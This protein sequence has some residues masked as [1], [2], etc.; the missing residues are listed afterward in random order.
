MTVRKVA[1]I[2]LGQM[3]APMAR[4]IHKAGFELT[5]CDLDEATMKP[6]A[7]LGARCTTR[8]AD[9]ADCDVVA[10]VV[11]TPAQSRTV[12]LGPEG[13]SSGI[14]GRAPIVA[15]MGTVSP[16]EMH[17]LAEELKPS[18]IQLVDA[19][20]SGG[21]MGA[22][23]GTLA[24]MVGGPKDVF[25]RVRPLME[26]MGSAI[27][28]CGELGTAQ[29]TKIVNNIAGI[30]TQMIAAE[31]YRI[32]TDNGIGLRDAI[33]VFETGTGR[34]FLTRDIADVTRAYRSWT[35]RR[36]DFDN[37]QTIMRKDI[38][39][40]L[41][42]GEKSGSLPT[43]NALFGVLNKVGEETYENWTMIAGSDGT[44]G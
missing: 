4:N 14:S 17:S 7:A 2:G 39:L 5:V 12:L 8:A 19:P 29:V 36:Q 13:I 27:Y 23:D 25:A 24:I 26:S 6:F 21:T 28:H 30:A 32:C 33:P 11:A 16:A 38:G 35:A 1:L 31:A 43:I 40:A 37:L 41:S 22:E 34:N 10:I 18:G 9:C 15:V 3:G 42:I 44:P 20:V